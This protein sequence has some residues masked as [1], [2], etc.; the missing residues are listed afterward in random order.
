M[1]T[2]FVTYYNFFWKARDNAPLLDWTSFSLNT[3]LLPLKGHKVRHS[4]GNKKNANWNF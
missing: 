2:N 4:R 1:L 3:Y